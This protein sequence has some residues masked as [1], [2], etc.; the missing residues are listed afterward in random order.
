MLTYSI[1]IQELNNVFV[2][3]F[4]SWGRWTDILEQGQFKR[5]WREQ[6]AEDCARVIVRILIIFFYCYYKIYLCFYDD[7]PC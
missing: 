6:D 5:G 4:F 2:F 3:L 1:T 7:S